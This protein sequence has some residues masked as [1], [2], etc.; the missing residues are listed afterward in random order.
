[1]SFPDNVSTFLRATDATTPEEINQI[2]EYQSLLQSGDFVGALNL[3]KSMQN[4][5]AM[6]INAS[7]YNQILD[8]ISNIETFL[9]TDTANYIQQN[10]DRYKDINLYSQSVDYSLG[11][12]VSYNGNLFTC[13]QA[14]GVSSTIVIPETSTS[15]NNY[16][17]YFALSNIALTTTEPAGL[18]DG[19]IW[20]EEIT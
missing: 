9:L 20:F 6:N 10:V 13:K 15:W 17:E 14:N 12:I 8:E 7:R 5:V 11:N 3:L 16:W 19:D 1:M 2:I 18:S 4:G